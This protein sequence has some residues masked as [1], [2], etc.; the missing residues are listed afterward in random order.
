MYAVIGEM[1]EKRLALGASELF[2]I[3]IQI[4]IERGHKENAMSATRS[5]KDKS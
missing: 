5:C 1:F 4:I 2:I 3:C